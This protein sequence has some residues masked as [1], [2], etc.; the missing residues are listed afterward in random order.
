M[1]R[2]ILLAAAALAVLLAAPA[3]AAPDAHAQR[4]I[5]HLLAFVASSGCRF[6]RGGVEH[7]AREARDHLARKLDVARPLIGSADA[8][9]DRVAS[10]SSLTGEPYRV[11]CGDGESTAKAWLAGELAR[12]RRAAGPQ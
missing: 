11:R 5:D 9:V 1:T 7:D 4:E 8:F 2:R 6:V 10:G 12:H 3:R